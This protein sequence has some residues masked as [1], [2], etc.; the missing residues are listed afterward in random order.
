MNE[1]YTTVKKRKEKE[2]NVVDNKILSLLN[3][4]HNELNSYYKKFLFSN[5]K[6]LR[7][8]FIL[9]VAELENIELNE[10]IFNLICSIELIHNASLIHDDILD[11]AVLR[12]NME[13]I[14]INKGDKIAVLAGDY[15]LTCAME[16]LSDIKNDCVYKIISN[17]AKD[18]T[19]SEINALL[20]RFNKISIEDYIK[21]SKEKTSSLFTSAISSLYKIK[22]M[23]ENKNIINFSESFSLCFQIKD[24]MN[25][26]LNKDECKCSKDIQEG[27]FTLPVILGAKTKNDY[28]IIQKSNKFLD[29]LIIKTKEFLIDYPNSGAKKDLFSLIDLFKG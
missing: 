13:C 4:C 15:L 21:I 7:P 3:S 5:A 25:N 28:D 27:I 2:L 9:L 14:H 12:R 26:F 22:E 19:K 18:M 1:I 17:A 16:C 24:D 29:D 20:T 10:D 8:L 6:R 11:D 23:K